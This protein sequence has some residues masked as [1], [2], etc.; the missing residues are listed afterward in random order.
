M[1]HRDMEISYLAIVS[2]RGFDPSKLVNDCSIDARRELIRQYDDL[3]VVAVL[4]ARADDLG[5][6]SEVIALFSLVSEFCPQF[7]G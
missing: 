4:Q 2:K 1:H 3:D 6:R 7:P 5:C